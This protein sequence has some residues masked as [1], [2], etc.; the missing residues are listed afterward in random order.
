MLV[1]ER[2]VTAETQPCPSCDGPVS[3]V[4][5]YNPWCPACNWNLNPLRKEEN[6]TLIQRYY[7]KAGKY[8]GDGL[9][10][11]VIQDPTRKTHAL[12]TV[13]AYMIASMVHIIG[14][15]VLLCGVW[16][17]IVGWGKFF[18]LLGAG[19]C[20]L[21]AWVTRPRFGRQREEVLER[22]E[23]PTL[24][25][26]VDEM[27]VLMGAKRIRG[28]AVNFDYN[29]AYGTYGLTRKSYVHLG[30]P[31]FSILQTQEQIALIA[32]EL[33]HGVNRD[34]SRGF[35]VGTAIDT[36]C[37][38]HY[39]IR[40]D[41]IIEQEGSFMDILMIPVN[42]LLL[43]LSNVVLGCIYLLSHLLWRDKQ[44]AEFFADY[45]AASVSGL[46]A[47]LGLLEK[48]HLDHM[49]R[50][51]VQKVAITKQ[52][53]NAFDEI[54]AQ[55]KQIPLSELERVKRI[56]RLTDARLDAT[57]PPTSS[58]IEFLEAK[59]Q[60]QPVYQISQ[61]DQMRLEGELRKLEERLTAKFVSYYQNHP[62][63]MY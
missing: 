24:Y 52:Q 53:G 51:A 46:D 34:T 31:L 16:L 18:F 36:L 7:R 44:R 48:L 43:G 6:D 27:A 13:F 8:F 5:G 12:S 32:H 26:I 45:L 22:S 58:R 42:V 60:H 62:A 55:F 54:R 1:N 50:F 10:Q 14:V 11:S 41:R 57:H 59:G 33:G 40:P 23:C 15:L 19:V 38:W 20:L 30:L 47:K 56:E 61:E 37:E 17:A 29:A 63:L 4:K 28:I 49:F 2:E 9:L 3:I 39:L 21:I 35:F 25:K